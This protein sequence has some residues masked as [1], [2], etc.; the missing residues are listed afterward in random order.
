[1]NIHAPS[2]CKAFK[3][4]NWNANK[5]ATCLQ[6]ADR[7]EDAVLSE[8]TTDVL[9]GAESVG[10]VVFENSPKPADPPAYQDIKIHSDGMQHVYS[11][12]DE[13][14]RIVMDEIEGNP[15][16]WLGDPGG[17]TNFLM[18]LVRRMEELQLP[19]VRLI[20]GSTVAKL[21]HL[22]EFKEC[23]EKGYTKT[24]AEILAEV[25]PST[26]DKPQAVTFS[27]L[28]HGWTRPSLCKEEAHPDDEEG[29]KAIGLVNSSTSWWWWVDYCCADQDNTAPYI[30]MLP[31]I[32]CCMDF[33]K[34]YIE[35]NER[36][37]TRAWTR[38]ERA[39]YAALK[40]PRGWKLH[41]DTAK[42]T[43]EGFWWPIQDPLE[44]ELTRNTDRKYI[45]RLS[46]VAERFWPINYARN[47][48][49]MKGATQD[50]LSWG[51]KNKLKYNETAVYAWS[52]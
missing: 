37:M 30:A 14:H 49:T 18:S 33:V 12:F 43:N 47:W 35:N 6:W 15:D 17:N 50:Y 52:V 21:K 19:P 5:C 3:P 34:S 26:V 29:T 48:R 46:D 38:V 28:S 31:M 16:M 40:S 8:K 39:L 32:I 51:F 45:E 36:Y 24:I 4:Q 13:V 11:S 23:I 25:P 20:H 7:H 10:N 22:P 27:L 42:W 41:E 2:A 1:M 44:G 9:A